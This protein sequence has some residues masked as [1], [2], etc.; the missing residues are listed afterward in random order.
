MDKIKIAVLNPLGE[1]K[2]EMEIDWSADQLDRFLSA[3]R[4]VV[5]SNEEPVYF[6]SDRHRWTPNLDKDNG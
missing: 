5:I 4:I 6:V 1:V 3:N 2:N